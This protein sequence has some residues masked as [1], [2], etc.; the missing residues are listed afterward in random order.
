MA[1]PSLLAVWQCIIRQLWNSPFQLLALTA[2]YRSPA[3]RTNLCSS[4]SSS[5]SSS[6]AG[7]QYAN[8]YAAGWLITHHR[9][10]PPVGGAAFAV[11]RATAIRRLPALFL[12]AVLLSS[13]NKF[14]GRR[15]NDYVGRAPTSSTCGRIMRTTVLR[16]ILRRHVQQQQPVE[17]SPACWH[18]SEIDI[19]VCLQ[20]DTTF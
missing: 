3:E 18:K 10:R 19:V 1:S 6:S 20:R 16:G 12:T 4:S 13:I 17:R 2:I 11:S 14:S 7:G 5:C 9:M 8:L 15:T